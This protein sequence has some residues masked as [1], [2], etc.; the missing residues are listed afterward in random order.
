M[1][2]KRLIIVSAALS[3]LLACSKTEHAAREK[4]QT[5]LAGV[6]VTEIK[7][8]SLPE[9]LEIVGTVRSRTTAMVSARIPG[10]VSMLRAK[11]GDRV[12]KGEVIARLDAQENQANARAA[13]EGVDD[14]RRALDEAVARKNLAMSQYERYRNL[15]KAEAVSRQEY[16]LK[17]T[18]KEVALQ[19]VARAEARLKQA[20][21]LARSAG[22]VADYTKIVAP[23]SG[24]VAARTVDLGATVFPAQPLFTIEDENSYQLEL[25]VP[26]S[27]V[28]KIRPG[29]AV[30]VALDALGVSQTGKVA[31]VVPAADPASRTFIVKVPL[32]QP[33]LRSGMFGRGS[34][35]L[36]ATVSGITVPKVSIVEH[37][38]LTSVWV[39][40]P[41]KVARMRLVKVGRAV[42]DRVEILSGLS[43]GERIITSGI[44]KVS[45]GAQ[46][47]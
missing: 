18:E 5:P 17:E 26:E 4:T 29:T 9:L 21:E 38:A 41:T 43:A 32:R 46:V 3:L 31:E 10:V 2:S 7:A 16:D 11:E 20:Q 37:G 23:I 6:G 15:L 47:E 39:V 27:Q 30:Q 40:D 42:N 1:V 8:E 24:I 33:G 36:G 45:D 28:A 35:M 14:A 34:V 25:A 13:A 22:T 19:G 44:D 12:S